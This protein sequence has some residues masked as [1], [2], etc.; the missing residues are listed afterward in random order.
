MVVTRLVRWGNSQGVRLPKAVMEQSRIAVGDE[1]EVQVLDG[2]I[3]LHP[4]RTRMVTIPDF[5]A[6][7]ADY[8]GSS[9]GEDGFAAARG[10]EVW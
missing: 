1:L 3:R 2:A 7:F 9:P 6:L 10:R 4:L 8:H 5:E